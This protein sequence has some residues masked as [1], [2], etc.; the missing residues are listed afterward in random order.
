MAS[1][2][3]SKRINNIMNKLLINII[4]VSFASGVITYSSKN[5]YPLFFAK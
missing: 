1:G 3:Q 2:P 5:H 4:T